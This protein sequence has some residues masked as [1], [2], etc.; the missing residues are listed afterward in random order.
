MKI[1]KLEP[2]LKWA[3][4][5]RQLLNDILPMIQLNGRDY[6]EPFIGGGAVLFGLQPEKAI[7]ND[8]NTELVNLYNVIK[9]DCEELLKE[10]EI[11][12]EKHSSEHYYEVRAMDR[13]ENFLELS[14]VVRAARI[15][16]LNR[17]C[18]NGLYRVNSKGY[19]NTPMG[20]YK[21]PKIV[22]EETI[23][24]IN[25]YFNE[26][27]VT[28]YNKDYKEVLEHIS[29]NS[30]VYLDP[31]YMPLTATA[32]FTS[33]T[34]SGFDYEEQVKLRDACVRLR[35]RGIPFLQSNSDTP[36]IRELY[37][38]FTITTVMAKRNINSKG[39]SRGAV[40]EVLMYWE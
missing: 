28:I 13:E 18:F 9:C 2:L 14:P 15:V 22:N 23:R 33:Y 11:H 34:D 3:G 29:D 8:F 1:E 5:K 32:A 25:Q 26:A 40:S 27:D 7:I 38:D 12:K 31:P 37:K 36:E 10:L 20:K 16:Y 6:V 39:N 4:G 19:Y 17:T 21:N 24:N 35:E 30:F